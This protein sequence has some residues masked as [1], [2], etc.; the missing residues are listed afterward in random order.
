MNQYSCI[1]KISNQD[2]VR[3]ESNIGFGRSFEEMLDTISKYWEDN[4]ERFNG[5]IEVLSITKV[6]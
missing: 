3:F 6:V 5:D 4:S 1:V 2:G